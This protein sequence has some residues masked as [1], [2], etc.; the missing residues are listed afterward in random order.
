MPY[1]LEVTPN[2]ALCVVRSA[3]P[4]FD[5][6]EGDTITVWDTTAG[7]KR[8]LGASCTSQGYGW[9]APDTASDCVRVTNE[10]AVLVGSTGFTTY[11]DVLDLTPPAPSE[12]PCMGRFVI[13]GGTF[14]AGIVGDVEITPD[15]DLA[16]VNHFNGIEVIS[17]TG[18]AAQ[19]VASFDCSAGGAKYADEAADSIA[20]TS[21]RAIVTMRQPQYPNGSVWVYII[22]LTANPPVI[23]NGGGAGHKLNA[24]LGTAPYK[25]HDVDIT[26]DGTLAVVS[27]N[28]AIGLYDLATG[29]C[30]KA[31]G[32]S[33]AVEKEYRLQADSVRVTNNRAVFIGKTNNFAHPN[34]YGIAVYA[35]D[36][37]AVDPMYFL[38][39]WGGVGDDQPH[40]LEV[41]VDAD[42]AVVSI[43]NQILVLKGLTAMSGATGW[44]FTAVTPTTPWIGSSPNADNGPRG[45]GTWVSDSVRIIPRW[46]VPIQYPPPVGGSGLRHYAAVLGSTP[47][48]PFDGVVTVVD[49]ALGVPAVAQQYLLASGTPGDKTVP[50]DVIARGAQRD[51]AVRSSALPDQSGTSPGRDWTHYTLFPTVPTTPAAN[52]GGRGTV[53]AFDSLEI[54]RGRSASVSESSGGF[55]HFVQ[56][57]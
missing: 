56:L 33:Q 7:A 48:S 13:N 47:N 11:I 35:L 10:R 25:H 5:S 4:G 49:L 36:P 23:I 16:V 55:F 21:T 29:A 39:V 8:T 27:A 18:A 50:A 9:G 3:T 57:P 51:F 24:A 54:R 6:H 37:A 42:L 20:V 15:G 31:D 52:F 45:V 44:S 26:P 12:I 30:L 41:D 19:L 43:P 22:D 32:P 46:V 53:F 28:W 40:D 34:A 1:D 38:Q 17:L 14:G 2:G